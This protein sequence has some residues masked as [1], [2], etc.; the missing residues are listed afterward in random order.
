M[1]VARTFA[2]NK[3]HG[4]AL[5]DWSDCETKR[6]EMNHEAKIWPISRAIEDDEGMADRIHPGGYRHI[7]TSRVR[8]CKQNQRPASAGRLPAVV[9]R[10]EERGQQRKR[11][12]PPS[13]LN[14][15]WLLGVSGDQL[16]KAREKS[17]AVTA[18]AFGR[19][20]FLVVGTSIPLALAHFRGGGTKKQNQKTMAES[21]KANVRVLVRVRPLNDRESRFNPASSLL[22][23]DRNSRPAATN[24]GNTSI[25]FSG[26]NGNPD[27]GAGGSSGT[28]S[29]S[30]AALPGQ[31]SGYDSGNGGGGNGSAPRQFTYDAVFGPSSTQES[32]Y[33]ATKGIVDGVVGGYNGCVLA[34]G[35]TGSGKTHTVFGDIESGDGDSSNDAEAG[36]VQ[37]SVA[38][39]FE[40]VSRSAG[41]VRTSAKASFFEIYNE[42]IYDLLNAPSD[43]SDADDRG[44][45]VRE[46]GSRGVYVEGLLEKPVADASGTMD[47][48]RSGMSNRTVAMTNM[49]RASSRSHAVFV[50]TVKTE[51]EEE[52]SGLTKTRV[53]KFTLVDLAGSERQK[54]TSADG[55]RL[56]EASMINGSLLTLGQVVGA[57]ADRE[58]GRDRHVPFRDSKLTFLLRD[59]WGGNA[60]TC[61]VATVTPSVSSLS[62]TVSTLKFAQRAKL[63][64]NSAVLNEDATG[65]V[66]ALRAEIARLRS[67]LDA[68]NG[69]PQEEDGGDRKPAALPANGVSS[70]GSGPAAVS[71]LRSHNAKLVDKVKALKDQTTHREKQVN[72]LKR[73]LQQ[74]TMVRKCKERRI[75]SLS[76]K[77]AAGDPSAGGG[78]D[79][80]AS[81]L[82]DEVRA[83]REQ[84]DGQPSES[85]EWMIKYKEEKARADELT[86]ASD[87]VPLAARERDELESS[88]VSLL[89]ERD[90]LKGKIESMRS[91]TNGE[92]DRILVDVGRLEESN[93]RLRSDL[94][95][96]DKEIAERVEEI[97]VREALEGVLTEQNE[98]TARERDDERERAVRARE[99]ADRLEDDLILADAEMARMEGTNEFLQNDLE[100]TCRLHEEEMARAEAARDGDLA[101]RDEAITSLEAK[102]NGAK[103]AENEANTRAE[104]LQDK[105]STLREA[106]AEMEDGLQLA[107][108]EASLAAREC[109]SL[110]ADI[111]RMN[112]LHEEELAMAEAALDG[113]LADRDDAI[114]TL[115]TEIARARSATAEANTRFES[116]QGDVFRLQV[117]LASVKQR[118]LNAEEGRRVAEQLLIGKQSEMHELESDY[119]RK[120]AEFE[121][122]NAAVEQTESEKKESES[123]KKKVET[124][125]GEVKADLRGAKQKL[126]ASQASVKEG[127]A[128]IAT[129]EMRKGE[130]ESELKMARSDLIASNESNSA[131]NKN[132]AKLL[133]DARKENRKL[134][135]QHG[136]LK[137]KVSKLEGSNQK[138]KGSKKE[139]VAQIDDLK[140]KLKGSLEGD[141]DIETTN[142]R[143]ALR[144]AIVT[145]KPK[146]SWDDVAGLEQVKETLEM[147]RKLSQNERCVC[148][149][150]VMFPVKYPQL[151]T[152]KRKPLKGI[153]L[154]GPPGTGKSYLAKAV[155]TETDSTFFSVSSSDLKTK[156]QGESERLVKNLFEM[157]RESP[158]ARAIIFID[159]IDSLCGSRK[160]GDS[161]GARGILT[162]FLKQMDGVGIQEND[163]LVL[164]ATNLPW[165]L[166]PAIRRR[167][168]MRVYIPLP[169]REARSGMV[170]IH[171][172]N[173]PNTLTGCDIDKLGQMT[174]G[175]SGSDIHVLVKRALLEPVRKCRK[176]Q[177]FLQVGSFLVPCKQY[178]NCSDCPVKLPA[179]PSS[180]SY[181]CSHCG[182]KSM[183]LR[184]V[185]P[186]KLK[187]PDVCIEDFES[188]LKHSYSSVSKEDLEKYERWTE[189]FGEVCA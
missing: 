105:V 106:A 132:S 187:A 181:D 9:Q 182:A 61:L 92:I 7:L 65:G 111:E 163:V 14:Q 37:R 144:E 22:V 147:R 76:S 94:A 170:K 148:S 154:Y 139:L 175:A 165:E 15:P 75:E 70:P 133:E 78:G 32:I 71:A 102:L 161:D 18:S 53:A 49:N 112:R 145:E 64:K 21:N 177:Q 54:S 124:R 126:E 87:L 27:G 2:R 85:V 162:E 95:G 67:E 20:I 43:P 35:Q 25:D 108:A 130:V 24:G 185:Q 88:L 42:R 115:E 13:S 158:G 176:A 107:D 186:E 172:G 110:R 127:Q 137:T 39:I 159:E 90:A 31:A 1:T 141:A 118:T 128:T 174:E 47:V 157:A 89:D 98:A 140:T 173:T 60:K 143:D 169:G 138:L 146:V 86:A 38:A 17:G 120:E 99:T 168:E 103:T 109:E 29:L 93:E 96:K 16:A 80:E 81:A 166:D 167:F 136:Q 73:K 36:L 178:P 156:W 129:L 28:I 171:L 82:R 55:E 5:S 46:D 10:E 63:V 33:Q 104:E 44:L 77:M 100:R 4:V 116:L 91:N 3:K 152:E 34:Y 114:A 164:G 66:A 69:S 40:G 41:S 48:L 8:I 153:L 134:R 149:R 97:R 123:E 68:R 30:D 183:Q 101:D 117:E 84:L 52:A 23:D 50:L 83:L 26:D 151:F 119:R 74:E 45:S 179:D 150:T 131:L 155:A 72:A 19:V 142:L 11:R 188:V 122:A 58:Q 79:T 56:K 135:Q 184:N 51:R 113:D 189:E 62:E 180:K 57:L 6:L 12:D 59:C 121:A 160:G 125:L